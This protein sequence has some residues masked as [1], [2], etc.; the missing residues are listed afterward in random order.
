MLKEEQII[1]RLEELSGQPSV[2]SD[3]LVQNVDKKKL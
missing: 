3:E 1:V 2:V